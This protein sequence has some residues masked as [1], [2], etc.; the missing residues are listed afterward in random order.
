MRKGCV[1]RPRRGWTCCATAAVVSEVLADPDQ[2]MAQS[3]VLRHWTAEPT[4]LHRGPAYELGPRRLPEPRRIPV[5]DP[6][7]QSWGGNVAAKVAETCRFPSR[8]VRRPGLPAARRPAVAGH[9]RRAGARM[10]PDRRGW[11][12][13]SEEAPLRGLCRWG[14]TGR[15]R[16]CRGRGHHLD[17]NRDGRRRKQ[18]GSLG[19]G[20]RRKARCHAGEH[21][22]GSRTTRGH[23]AGCP[24]RPG[25][26]VKSRRS[27]RRRRTGRVRRS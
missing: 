20:V 22:S 17:R 27:V 23:R 3:A 1:S 8:A 15:A 14:G 7:G 24:G 26:C 5:P 2:T 4:D 16:A 11:A 21:S 9:V 18:V 6:D 13:P 25:R 10:E 12:S 19:E